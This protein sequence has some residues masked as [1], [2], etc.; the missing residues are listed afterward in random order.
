M[1]LQQLTPTSR[2]CEP[3]L[4][5]SL[6]LPNAVANDDSFSAVVLFA[7]HFRVVHQQP[8]ARLGFQGPPSLVCAGK[9]PSFATGT[10]R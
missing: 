8:A 4:I 5:K 7:T 6:L 1:H 3:L 9:A 2:E 10:C